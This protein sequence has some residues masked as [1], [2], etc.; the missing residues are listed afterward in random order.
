MGLLQV[1]QRISKVAARLGEIVPRV[2]QIAYGIVQV[3]DGIAQ[4]FQ[5]VVGQD[6]HRPVHAVQRALGPDQLIHG[7]VHLGPQGLQGLTGQAAI[8]IGIQDDLEHRTHTHSHAPQ[9]VG[10]LV[11]AQDQLFEGG[12]GVRVAAHRP[13]Q[14]IQGIP[15][16]VQG[17]LG[18]FVGIVHIVP[19]IIHIVRRIV[20]GVVHLT[21][22]VHGVGQLGGGLGHAV[23]R[24]ADGVQDG[25]HLV[26]GPGDAGKGIVHL[27]D[28]AVAPVG[29]G[30]GQV[31]NGI[32]CRTGAGGK[33]GDLL[34]DCVHCGSCVT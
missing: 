4:I 1:G 14:V 13:A 21:H 6:T 12:G 20:Q 7:L 23:H 5:Q 8:L 29:H 9:G 30:I 27:V 28:V 33:V 18:P 15:N 25:A 3:V 26:Q 16:G 22:T 2:L 17:I 10:E 24:L 31:V 34:G 32:L 11:H 19:G